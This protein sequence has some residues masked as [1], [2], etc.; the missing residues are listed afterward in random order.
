MKVAIDISPLGDK[1][2]LGH[3]VRGS[4][5]YIEN[6]KN[7]LIKNFGEENFIFFSKGEKINKKYNLI[8][9][10]YFE[11]FFLT[12]PLNLQNKTVVTVH[13]LTPFV[14]PEYFPAGL[15]GNLKWNIQKRNL[16]KASAIITDSLSSKKDIVKFTGINESKIHVVYLAASSV[17]RPAKNEIKIQEI[18]KKYELPEKFVLYV[19]DATRNKNLVNLITACEKANVLLVMVGKALVEKNFDHSNLWNKD[20]AEVQRLSEK[21]TKIKRLGFIPNEDLPFLYN[22]ATLF[23]IPSYYEGFGLPVL[24]AMQS[25]TPV[26]TTKGGSIPEV[27]GEAALYVN[28]D[29]SNDIAAAIRKVYED[30]ALQALLSKKGLD[31]AKKFSWD[32]TAKETERVYEKAFDGK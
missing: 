23:A 16:K 29:D 6:L 13:D 11:P 12:L 26:V 25:G 10:P 17:Y 30:K 2:I 18:R 4:G 32:I 1:R 31:Q 19:G 9:Y 20:L 21:S 27:G 3:S 28:P 5:Y 8:H 22:L 15:K 14:F 7:S 24:E